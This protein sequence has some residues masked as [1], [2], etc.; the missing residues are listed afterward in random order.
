MTS[1]SKL[2]QILD[3]IGE[4]NSRESLLPLIESL[5]GLL[6]SGAE[7]DLGSLHK[8]P[9]IFSTV[10]ALDYSLK[11]CINGAA[12]E[13]RQIQR[14]YLVASLA[15][16]TTFQSTI[17]PK[18]LIHLIIETCTLSSAVNRT[19]K[20]FFGFAATTLLFRVYELWV[21]TDDR[22]IFNRVT[23][24]LTDL[25]AKNGFA[26]PFLAA[27]LENAPFYDGFHV[28]LVEKVLGSLNASTPHDLELLITVKLNCLPS[29]KSLTE[30]ALTKSVSK[31]AGEVN[32]ALK[33]VYSH[34]FLIK[35]FEAVNKDPNLQ[36]EV[37]VSSVYAKL[38]QVFLGQDDLGVKTIFDLN[39]A[40]L[41]QEKESGHGAS[42][43]ANLALL[44]AEVF[45]QCPSLDAFLAAV[46]K[47]GHRDALE[48]ILVNLLAKP[49]GKSKRL[50]FAVGAIQD[51]LGKK[52]AAAGDSE[53]T[54]AFLL[55]LIFSKRDM[56]TGTFPLKDVLLH[57][58]DNQQVKHDI[59]TEVKAELEDPA[60]LHSLAD[61]RTLLSKVQLILPA[62]TDPGLVQSCF[63]ALFRLYASSPTLVETFEED[64]KDRSPDFLTHTTR[65]LIFEKLSHLVFKKG[66]RKLL[67]SLVEQWLAVNEV[68]DEFANLTLASELES[69]ATKRAE[70]LSKLNM[71]LLF[72]NYQ[73]TDE[74]LESLLFN[75][76]TEDVAVFSQNYLANEG[77]LDGSDFK[78]LTDVLVSLLNCPNHEIRGVVR[79]TFDGFLYLLDDTVFEL[80]EDAVFKDNRIGKE[81]EEESEGGEEQGEEEEEE[82]SD[83]DEEDEEEGEG[84]IVI[85]GDF[86]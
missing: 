24:F 8:H 18:P 71:V 33:S 57:K 39:S 80:V 74:D 16:F 25:V 32:N 15:L 9:V 60:G 55:R 6:T 59:L 5:L 47:A 65:G 48:A 75:Q 72:Q 81:E 31:M 17:P 41:R 86:F 21:E 23:V 61:L 13:D 66:F 22:T 2:V 56:I 83:E 73:E 69:Q 79:E 12:V 4:C 85:G 37:A 50:L 45:R 62:V 3:S 78:I 20:M 19:E 51:N 38:A 64:L 14:N 42:K 43:A 58:L 26:R 46:D 27:A 7:S 77:K 34:K 76:S 49:Q 40:V 35:L 36:D 82:D 44:L 28:H 30:P 29:W 10:T 84:D 1:K 53:A 70:A 68:E 63:E 11:R 52:L 67:R 54:Q